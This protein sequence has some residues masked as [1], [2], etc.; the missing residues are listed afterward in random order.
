MNP[1][2]IAPVL[3]ASLPIGTH[4]ILLTLTDCTMWSTNALTVEV[5]TK[6][7][8]IERLI[9]M[10][11]SAA[12]GQPGAVLEAALVSVRRDNSITAI[13]QLAAFQNQ[14][15]AQILPHDPTLAETLIRSAQDVM[16]ALVP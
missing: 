7:E 4:R 11:N 14:V 9:S 1:I 16:A 12:H 15:R 2:G 3:P 6:A 13:N 10:V 5:L 8:A